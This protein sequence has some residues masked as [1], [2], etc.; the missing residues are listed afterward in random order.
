MNLSR[1]LRTMYRAVPF[2]FLLAAITSL[3]LFPFYW[4][5][6]SSLKFEKDIY[7]FSGNFLISERASLGNY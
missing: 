6:M 5:F 7:D 2:Y 1:S 3:L 4:G